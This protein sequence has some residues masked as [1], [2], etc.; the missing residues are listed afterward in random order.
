M[1]GLIAAF[2]TTDAALADSW[3][4]RVAWRRGLFVRGLE[5]VLAY[6]AGGLWAVGAISLVCD[7]VRLGHADGLAGPAG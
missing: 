5:D 1:P 4:D 3:A 6:G 2:D 7:L